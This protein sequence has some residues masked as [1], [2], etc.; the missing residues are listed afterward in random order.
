VRAFDELADSLFDVVG[1]RGQARRQRGRSQVVD[2]I[3]KDDVSQPRHAQ[4]LAVEARAR[5][6]IAG[7]AG[8]HAVPG[9]AEAEHAELPWCLQRGEARR[10]A[11]AGS[12]EMTR[13]RYR[14]SE[15]TIKE[16]RVAK[17]AGS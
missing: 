17:P 6:R 8:E 7:R 1:I 14:Q 9:D 4:H 16:R 11:I 3:G 5:R 10:G 15:T 12:V 2:P 13:E